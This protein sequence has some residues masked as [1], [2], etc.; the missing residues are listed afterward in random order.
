MT[1]QRALKK[2]PICH[3]QGCGLYRNQIVATPAGSSRLTSTRI[4][5]LGSQQVEVVERKISMVACALAIVGAFATLGTSLLLLAF[6]NVEKRKW[7]TQDTVRISGPGYTLTVTGPG[8]REFVNRANAWRKMLI[9]YEQAAQ[10]AYPSL[11]PRQ[12]SVRYRQI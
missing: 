6:S 7:I 11:V 10:P 9:Q 12:G 5:I 3:F 8:G 2:Q 1:S 4:D